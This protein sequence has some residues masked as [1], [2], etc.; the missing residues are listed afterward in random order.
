MIVSVVVVAGVIQ[1]MGA[2][3]RIRSGAAGIALLDAAINGQ[4]YRQAWKWLLR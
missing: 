4:E 2:C 3:S 1:S